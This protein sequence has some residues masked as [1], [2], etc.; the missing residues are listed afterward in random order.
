MQI[1]MESVAL[2]V[3]LIFGL[4]L[5]YLLIKTVFPGIILK[6]RLN[7]EGSLGRG[8][9]KLK[10]PEGRAVIYEPHPS[11]RKYIKKYMLF[12]NGGIK[13]L[14]C[15]ID[16]GISELDYNVVMFDNKNR[17]IDTLRIS[18]YLKRSAVSHTVIL[19]HN[20][21][22]VALIV[23]SVNG[24]KLQNVPMYYYKLSAVCIYGISV[25]V[26]SFLM[27]ILTS[28]TADRLF[29][30][31]FGVEL[32]IFGIPASFILPSLVMGFAATALSVWF[33]GKKGARLVLNDRK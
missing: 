21:S 1:V 7:S 27:F 22:Y 3:F 4:I 19:H 8:L 14:K 12:S 6:M 30:V 9:R 15:E 11:I 17:V 23:N 26:A 10:S 5:Y 13:H 32:G 33:G 18:D 31:L 25:A 29:D 16:E 2:S 24:E 28:W 20:T